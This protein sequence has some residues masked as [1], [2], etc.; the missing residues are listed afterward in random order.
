M[1]E[2]SER[3][4]VVLEEMSC[5]HLSDFCRVLHDADE[6]RCRHFFKKIDHRLFCRRESIDDFLVDR[7]DDESVELCGD[8]RIY[9]RFEVEHRQRPV[10]AF[11]GVLDY[12]GA[13]IAAERSF[14]FYKNTDFFHCVMIVP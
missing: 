10:F 12:A 8:G 11:L 4:E 5:R 6:G 3:G 7:A 9:R 2:E 1:A 14:P 13:K